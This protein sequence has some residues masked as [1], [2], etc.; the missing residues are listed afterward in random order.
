MKVRIIYKNGYKTVAVNRKRGI[1]ERCL[2]CSNWNAV[3]VELCQQTDCLLYKYRMKGSNQNAKERERD[4]RKYCLAC[5]NGSLSE[6]NKCPVLDCP[7]YVFR[8]TKV[9]HSIEIKAESC[10]DHIGAF[11]RTVLL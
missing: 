11:S 3:E 9:D 1:R 6:V 7:L 2:N 5:C 10:K 8:Q 4:L